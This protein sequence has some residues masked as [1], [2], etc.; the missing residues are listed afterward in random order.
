M[1]ATLES[2]AS[3]PLITLGSFALAIFAI[4]LAVI[5]YI[6]SQKYKIPCFEEKSY[7]IIEGLQKSLEGL[8]V[9]Y[10]ST[11]QERIT[12]TKVIFWNDGKE[13]IDKADTVEKDPLRIDV[14]SSIDVLDIQV[15]DVSSDS[16]SVDIG[17][18]FSANN[19]KT[20]P[21]SFEYLDH[22]E[23]FVIQIIHNG[24]SRERFGIKGKIKGVKKLEKIMGTPTRLRITTDIPFL[25]PLEALVNSSKIMK[26]AYSLI[27]FAAGLFAIWHLFN[28]NTD[29][30]IWV[31]AGISFLIAVF[32]YTE[33]R[34]ISPVKI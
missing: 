34:H 33:S 26:Y 15:I 27:Y 30:Y 6:R 4:V 8:E 23:Y 16:N 9:H 11:V 12:V 21:L 20:Y 7:T 32:M 14:P 22:N 31:L 10:K 2:L 29:W 18:A 13:T 19:K 3:N 25:L 28:G 24:A 1:G 17:D 5:F